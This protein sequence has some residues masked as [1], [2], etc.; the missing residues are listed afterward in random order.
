MSKKARTSGLTTTTSARAIA[1]ALQ[2]V[3]RERAR[4]RPSKGPDVR[5]D[6]AREA[7]QWALRRFLDGW[8]EAPAASR[9]WRPATDA[10]CDASYRLSFEAPVCVWAYEQ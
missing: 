4:I 3:G 6:A 5:H 2:K 1:A 9:P 7:P 8:G 10:N